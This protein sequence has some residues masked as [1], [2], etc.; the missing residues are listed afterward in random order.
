MDITTVI[1]IVT[2]MG[3]VTNVC[4]GFG[5]NDGCINSLNSNDH[6]CFKEVPDYVINTAV[7]WPTP[8]SAGTG[9]PRILCYGVKPKN[10]TALPF[11]A[12]ECE[13]LIS[14]LPAKWG[15]R[16]VQNING[17]I[18]DVS[19]YPRVIQAYENG[20]CGCYKS[21]DGSKCGT[22]NCCGSLLE[23]PNNPNDP[24]ITFEGWYQGVTDF[25][26]QSGII[27]RISTT[28]HTLDSSGLVD[29]SL[30]NLCEKLINY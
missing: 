2:I 20:N 8:E 24:Q 25:I 4:Y 18:K 11:T 14:L 16:S 9:R 29:I 19:L 28:A 10:S 6:T 12:F 27:P 5:V 13:D 26:I 30:V 22:G 23:L 1:L 17:V 7:T 3:S 15:R 21:P